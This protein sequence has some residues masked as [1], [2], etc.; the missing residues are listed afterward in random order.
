MK[1]TAYA[2]MLILAFL[3]SAGAQVVMVMANAYPCIP[4]PWG[5]PEIT[6]TSPVQNGTYP[7]NM[8]G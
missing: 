7:Q 2:M 4:T 5:Y 1:K 8:F 3:F 6:V